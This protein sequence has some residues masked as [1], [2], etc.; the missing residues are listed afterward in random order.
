MAG[1][2]APQDEH[3]S[4]KPDPSIRVT[5][6]ELVLPAPAPAVDGDGHTDIGDVV[7]VHRV[8]RPEAVSTAGAAVRHGRAR[9]PGA[10]H[11]HYLTGNR[12]RVTCWAR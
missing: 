1:T 10:V 3:D 5:P 8:L 4:G 7:R 9:C 12:H 6:V 11:E 2:A